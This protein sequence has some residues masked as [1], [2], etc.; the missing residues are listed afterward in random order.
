MLSAIALPLG[1][2]WSV[3]WSVVRFVVMGYRVPSFPLNVNLWSSTSVVSDPPDRTCM[4][5]LSPGRRV[6][7][8]VQP[9]LDQSSTAH[10]L[11]SLRSMTVLMELMVPAGTDIEGWTGLTNNA[12]CAE[13]P[14]GSGVYYAVHH[15]CDVAKGFSNEYRMAVLVL[16][17]SQWRL[18][19]GDQW[20]TPDLPVPLP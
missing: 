6:M 2:L 14:A 10:F 18:N 3:V 19:Y 15:V 16:L 11:A 9:N 7:L 12:D 17:T 8:A 20:S 4:G 1:L 13:V 5:N